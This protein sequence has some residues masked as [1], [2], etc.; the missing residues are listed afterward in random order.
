LAVQLAKDP[1]HVAELRQQL[2]T[3]LANTPVFDPKTFTK[4]LETRYIE[5]FRKWYEENDENLSQTKYF[6]ETREWHL[7]RTI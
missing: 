7:E 5:V 1:K 2:R 4:G 6:P 3:H